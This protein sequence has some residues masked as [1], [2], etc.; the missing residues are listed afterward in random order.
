LFVKVVEVLNAGKMRKRM[1]V[2]VSYESEDS[3]ISVTQTKKELKEEQKRVIDYIR[4]LIE[5]DFHEKYKIK[6]KNAKNKT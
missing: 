3:D 5:F 2:E 6:I 4:E 1:Y